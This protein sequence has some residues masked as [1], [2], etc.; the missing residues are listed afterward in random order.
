M[1]TTPLQIFLCQ[2]LFA[3]AQAAL[4]P[5]PVPGLEVS[6][7]SRTCT[8]RKA[9]LEALLEEAGRLS[10]QARGALLVGGGCL[11]A[12]QGLSMPASLGLACRSTCFH[13]FLPPE[14]VQA[15]LR[16]GAY[17]VTAG[18]LRDWQKAMA[19]W[20]L[21]EGEAR[22]FFAESCTCVVLV[23]VGEDPRVSEHL[24]AFAAFVGLPGESVKAEL[25]RFRAALLEE[26]WTVREAQMAR[27]AEE[28]GQARRRL[29]EQAALVDLVQRL[30]AT[31]DEGAIVAV[32]LEVAESLFAPG[33]MLWLSH[34]KGQWGEA[35]W[36]P[37]GPPLV[38]LEAELRACAAGVHP[39]ASGD[40]MLLRFEGPDGPM[41]LLGL[42]RLAFPHQIPTYL[43]TAR[44]LLDAA[45]LAL[46]NARNL[47]GMIRICAWCRQVK[48][49]DKGWGTFE[50]YLH[51]QSS[52]TF[53]HGMCPDCASRLAEQTATKQKGLADS[54]RP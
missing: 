54:G 37:P 41:G 11:A 14:Q 7:L 12:L 15:L 16:R 47:H 35:Q 5:N 10:E 18:W 38:G 29:A 27:Q 13:F 4:A 9:E 46:G 6:C 48:D 33:T 51:E 2:R 36:V 34:W 22:T 26:A 43:E 30:S 17:L 31:I 21:S 39:M 42:A 49:E 45:Q 1:K 24:A 28:L 40:G 32:L 8:P 25:S 53:S 3:E 52:A 44:T 50:D 19:E 20:G 23:E